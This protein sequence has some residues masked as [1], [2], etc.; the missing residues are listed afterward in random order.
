MNRTKIEWTDY[1]W[2]PVTGC[3]KISQGCKFCYAER[4]ANRFAATHGDFKTV[5][6][7]PERLDQPIKVKKSSRVFVCDVSDL[8]H[9]DVP[10][11]FILE[12]FQMMGKASQH[13]FQILTKRPE[14]M[15]AFYKW[16]CENA[17]LDFDSIKPDQAFTSNIWVG[18]SCED[19]KTADE[20]IP[21]LIKVP[22]EVRFL[23]CEP[24]LGPINLREIDKTKLVGRGRP[25]CWID[26]LDA[27]PISSPTKP[28]INWVIA[29]GESGPKARPV[30][31]DWIRS[32]RD[33]CKAA[34]VPFFFKQWGEWIDNQNM[35]TEV[36]KGSYK[37]HLF[38]SGYFTTE[39]WKVGKSKTGNLLDAVQHFEF[40]K[41]F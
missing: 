16:A 15:L 37:Q 32:L 25:L 1:T 4:M 12:V 21:F 14:R 30:H 28:F 34:N 31:P 19:Q 24:L 33:Q 35:P 9:E 39:V 36:W 3:T 22:A 11:D 7:H 2:N 27:H 10:F 8:F 38:G 40:P 29:G 26:A 20:R 23:S 6:L 13:T 5:K 41:T 17:G 18:T